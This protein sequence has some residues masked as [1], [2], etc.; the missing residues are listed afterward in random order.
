M[1]IWYV[2]NNIPQIDK[3]VWITNLQ[4]WELAAW[5]LTHQSR[6]LSHHLPWDKSLSALQA[7]GVN[8]KAMT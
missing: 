7:S 4:R 1:P 8:K 3:W 6:R 5:S 2:N